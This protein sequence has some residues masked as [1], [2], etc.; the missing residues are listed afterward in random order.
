MKNIYCRRRQSLH[1]QLSD[2]STVILFSGS[3]V[4][5]SADADYKF[6]TNN[7][8]FYLTGIDRD[9]VIYLCE[10]KNNKI[11]EMLF[12]KKRNADLEKWFG[13]YLTEDECRSKSGIKEI[14]FYEDFDDYLLKLLNNNFISYAYLDL[15]NHSFESNATIANKYS[16]KLIGK[17]PHII[18]K[19]LHPIIS[20]M[21]RV[22]DESE[23]E[24][25]K[26]SIKITK[27]AFCHM[28]QNIKA[29]MKEYEMEA[30]YNLI[31]N[32]N[33]AEP[34]FETIAA[35]GGNALILHYIKNNQEVK[36][37]DMI[38]FDLGV[39]KNKYCSDITRTVPADGIYTKRQK[40]LYE[41]VLEAN[42]RVIDAAKPGITINELNETAKIIIFEGLLNLKLLNNMDELTKFYYH[43]VSHYLGLDV[44]D[45]GDREKPLEPGCLI[46]VEPGLYVWD[47]GIGIRIEDNILITH[48]GNINLSSDI[49]KETYEI[50][51]LMKK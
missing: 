12:I 19:N 26:E 5:K 27:D 25:V 7:H 42:K 37:G 49:P 4:V 9:D 21:R 8:F 32:L 17:Y 34:S 51:K 46:T 15:E 39:N 23:I 14:N 47:E 31:L 13:L 33:C 24:S 44:H 35:S 40:V 38:L 18:Q 11:K 3:S 30:H 29:G 10:K 50:E 22:K 1:E 2:D 41:I 45:V 16:S 36:S 6:Y 43:G 48:G 28:L 20:D